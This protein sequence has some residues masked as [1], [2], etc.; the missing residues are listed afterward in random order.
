MHNYNAELLMSFNL[1]LTLIYD[2][3]FCIFLLYSVYNFKKNFEISCKKIINVLV[4][5][6]SCLQNG[7]LR[8]DGI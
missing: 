1:I 3:M 5:V 2:F 7:C 8:E 6:G 4:I